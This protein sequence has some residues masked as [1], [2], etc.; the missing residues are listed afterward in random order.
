MVIMVFVL[1]GK[2]TVAVLMTTDGW[3]VQLCGDGDGMMW[4][5]VWVVCM[6]CR[7]H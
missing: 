1:A 7:C 5:H 3:V 4:G 2:V 6:Y